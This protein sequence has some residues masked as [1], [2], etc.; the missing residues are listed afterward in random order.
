MLRLGAAIILFVVATLSSSFTLGKAYQ[1]IS[2]SASCPGDRKIWVNTR[3]GV[4]HLEGERW[5]GRTKQGHFGCERAAIAGG[6]RETRN[7]SD[8]LRRMLTGQEARI[9]LLG[10][11]RLP[12]PKPS[13][14]QRSSAAPASPAVPPY[15]AGRADGFRSSSGTWRGA[16]THRY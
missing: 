13:I 14:R 6:D 15:E 5:Y 7:G 1:P 8:L 11:T 9:K 12:Q 2:S 4:Y 16:R 10:D 3:T